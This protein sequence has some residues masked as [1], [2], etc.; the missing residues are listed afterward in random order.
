[1]ASPGEAK[2]QEDQEKSGKSPKSQ[3]DR[4]KLVNQYMPFA[5]YIVRKVSKT[6]SGSVDFED[7]LGYAKIGLI[8]A[9]ERFDSR[10]K[11]DFRTFA[12]YRIRGAIYDGL[13]T[14]GWLSRTQFQKHQFEE[15]SN[16]YLKSMSDR[17]AA[18]GSANPD[19]RADVEKTI[20]NLAS[21]YIMSLDAADGMQIKD[22]S[23][24]AA[25][26][27]YELERTRDRVR[28][29][30]EKLPVKERQL[31][32]LYYYGGMTLDEAGVS[33]GLSRSWTSRLHARALEQ[34]Q[35]I[36]RESADHDEF[37]EK[38]KPEVEEISGKITKEK[39]KDKNS[40]KK[41]K[42]KRPKSPSEIGINSTRC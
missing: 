9:A 20:L 37:K 13:R 15:A 1:V 24:E 19:P 28:Q 31:I 16:N 22:E 2:I 30:I 17:I 7:L 34:L 11:V 21:V 5:T 33:L 4:D 32:K 8:E 39:T 18:G 29:A 25:D 12:F 38:K 42:E 40:G 35:K 36:I 14:T 27:K 23:A 41:A 10:Y 6:I 26:S 3:K